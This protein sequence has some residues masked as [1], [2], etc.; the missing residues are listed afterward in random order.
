MQINIQKMLFSNGEYHMFTVFTGRVG[1][2]SKHIAK[3]ENSVFNR[4]RIALKS[5]LKASN[6][7]TLFIFIQFRMK[8]FGLEEHLI[9]L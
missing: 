5:S 8:A 4:S 9:K 6:G 7:D 2:L 3:I 1:G